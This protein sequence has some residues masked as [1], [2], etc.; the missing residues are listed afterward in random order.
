[1]SGNNSRD[2]RAAL[3]QILNDMR[4]FVLAIYSMERGYSAFFDWFY[5]ETQFHEW[6]AQLMSQAGNVGLE[7][8]DCWAII[9]FVQQFSS[10]DH[11]RI[12]FS[13][14]SANGIRLFRTSAQTLMYFG[15]YIADKQGKGENEID[16]LY[17]SLKLYLRCF[18]TIMSGGYTNF[19]VFEMYNDST[20]KDLLNITCALIFGLD[21]DQLEV[22]TITVSTAMAAT[23]PTYDDYY[24]NKHTNSCFL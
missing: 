8:E 21:L 20:L 3:T 11:T 23:R 19:G 7:P 17:K 2:A 5:D 9:H 18:A 10:N 13:I 24:N 6:L 16:D 15:R 14:T 12:A 1:M 22:T 4:G